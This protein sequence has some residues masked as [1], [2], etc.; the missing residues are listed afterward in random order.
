MR[1]ARCC[2]FVVAALTLTGCTLTGCTTTVS[3][4]GRPAAQAA[5]AGTGAPTGTGTPT[6]SGSAVPS[7]ADA[8]KIW[9]AVH[10]AVVD[11]PV[12]TVNGTFAGG[13]MPFDTDGDAR[14]TG[15]YGT[16]DGDPLALVTVT[17]EGERLEVRAVGGSA[18]V[19]AAASFYTKYGYDAPVA[20]KAANLW[21][22]STDDDKGLDVLASLDAFLQI[23]APDDDVDD[24]TASPATSGGVEGYELASRT[25]GGS[26]L[27][28]SDP[29]RLVSSQFSGDDLDFTYTNTP[30]QVEA[31]PADQVVR[32]PGF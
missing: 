17:V 25:E 21:V 20:A 8:D 24:L 1:R 22:L 13:G 2:A 6:G 26:V 7:G 15:G 12:V 27:V 3:G 10:D 23:C 4:A 14:I 29:A 18:W 28:T 31:P 9:A 5:A 19:R 11:L 16:R 32:L 30:L